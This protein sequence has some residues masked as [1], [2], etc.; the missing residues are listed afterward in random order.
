MSQK[1]V[2]LL[3]S[4]VIVND[5]DTG[6]I[7]ETIQLNEF[8]YEFNKD[9]VQLVDSSRVGSVFT[10]PFNEFL[11]DQGGAL[12]TSEAITGYL[13]GFSISAGSVTISGPIDLAPGTAVQLLDEASEQLPQA[14]Q[15]INPD[16]KGLVLLGESSNGKLTRLRTT[17]DGRL[18]STA[19]VTNPPASTPI[20]EVQQSPVTGV[21]DQDYIIP[22]GNEVVLQ[23]LSAGAEADTD[24]SKVE[25]FYFTDATKLTGV[26]LSALYVNGSN[27]TETTI[28]KT[29]AGNGLDGRITLRRSRLA[30]PQREIYGKWVGYY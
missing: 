21:D 15:S 6:D 26:L 11:D 28:F 7:L 17:D 20:F 24:G 23:S 25:L 30:G 22:L 14:N 8:S 19:Q 1:I 27:G 16:A 2:K 18:V 4:T 12:E 5:N 3:G 13:S 10:I 29:P 9:T